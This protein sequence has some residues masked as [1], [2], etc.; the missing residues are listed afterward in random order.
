MPGPDDLTRVAD[1][2]LGPVQPDADR[3]HLGSR[4]HV[5]HGDIARAGVEEGLKLALRVLHDR[6]GS[7]GCSPADVATARRD[8]EAKVPTPVVEPRESWR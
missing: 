1:I 7:T 2:A 8:P 5:D 4:C 6:F 3:V